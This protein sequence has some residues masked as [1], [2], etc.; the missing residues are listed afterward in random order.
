MAWLMETRPEMGIRTGILQCAAA[1]PR[2]WTLNHAW[3]H[4]HQCRPVIS[5]AVHHKEQLEAFAVSLGIEEKPGC[6][7]S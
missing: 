2:L 1:P 5:P 4:V 6:L 3:Q 7:L